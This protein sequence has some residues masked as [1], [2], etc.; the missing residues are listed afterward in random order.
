MYNPFVTQKYSITTAQFR[1]EDFQRAGLKTEWR[2]ELGENSDSAQKH[3]NRISNKKI[4]QQTKAKDQTAS[5]V[6]STKN[7]EES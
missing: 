3:G 5:Q 6:N 7:L 1:K 2:W 4:F